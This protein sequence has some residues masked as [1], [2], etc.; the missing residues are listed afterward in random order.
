[1]TDMKKDNFEY[2]IS[3]E[4]LFFIMITQ[5]HFS[6]YGIEMAIFTDPNAKG[7]HLSVAK[8]DLEDAEVILKYWQD[9]HNEALIRAYSTILLEKRK[10]YKKVKNFKKADWIRDAFKQLK[11]KIVDMPGG[12]KLEEE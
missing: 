6:T 9:N 4:S 11:L 2:F 12:Y 10:Y 5:L 1:M 3:Y 8:E 7:Y